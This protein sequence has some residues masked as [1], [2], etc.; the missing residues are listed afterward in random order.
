MGTASP[1]PHVQV[2]ADDGP[3][4]PVPPLQLLQLLQPLQPLPTRRCWLTT[5]FSESLVN[6]LSSLTNLSRWLGCGGG[7]GTRGEGAVNGKPGVIRGRG[8]TAV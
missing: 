4:P 1:R 7:G 5:A 6:A 3:P 2:L 8:R